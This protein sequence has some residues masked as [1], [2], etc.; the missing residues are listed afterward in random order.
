MPLDTRQLH[1]KPSLCM[2]E[3]SGVPNLQMELNYL[4]LF[5]NN[6][7]LSEFAFFGFGDG[8]VVWGVSGVTN[9]SLCKLG[10][11]HSKRIFKQN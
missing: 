5:K 8:A 2:Q 11:L 6:C 10:S 9:Y 1:I 3:G 7:I 4:N